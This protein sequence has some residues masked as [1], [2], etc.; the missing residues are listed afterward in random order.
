MNAEKKILG[1]DKEKLKNIL[2][3]IGIIG[4]ALLGISM[5]L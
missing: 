1:F 5:L 3:G 4:I 2:K